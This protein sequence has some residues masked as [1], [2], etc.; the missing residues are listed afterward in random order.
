MHSLK[1][2]FLSQQEKLT[3][4]GRLLFVDNILLSLR[5]GCY[6]WSIPGHGQQH[7]DNCSKYSIIV[8]LL[9]SSVG[10]W[11]DAVGA[12]DSGPDALCGHWSLRDGCIPERW[13]PNSPANQLSWWAVSFSELEDVGF[14]PFMILGSKKKSR[15]PY[16]YRDF[17]LESNDSLDLN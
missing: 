6:L 5:V 2:S 12:H 1:C 11:S 13:L 4:Y 9:L 15:C 17:P 10:L 14:I 8:F 7:S 3:S 16:S